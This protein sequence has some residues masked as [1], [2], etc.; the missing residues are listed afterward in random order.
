MPID[1]ISNISSVPLR[2]KFSKNCSPTSLPSLD[3][4]NNQPTSIAT[5]LTGWLLESV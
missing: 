1:S 5:T 2:F 3:G 4:A